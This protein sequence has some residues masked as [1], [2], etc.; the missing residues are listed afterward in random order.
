MKS[1]KLKITSSPQSLE[2]LASK[3][4]TLLTL[5]ASNVALINDYP[6]D[7]SSLINRALDM[8]NARYGT[9]M[10]FHV[11][12]NDNKARENKEENGE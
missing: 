7:I 4:L 2:E 9:A 1:K 11:A 8:W 6:G 10:R 3:K 5:T 12:Q